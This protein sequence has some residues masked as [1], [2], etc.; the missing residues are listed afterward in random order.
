MVI[1]AFAL[2]SLILTLFHQDF[3]SSMSLQ[4]LVIF[5]PFLGASNK[6][7]S[8]YVKL[9][10]NYGC[11]VITHKPSLID[12]LWP[13]TGLKN[14]TN[15]LTQIQTNHKVG[16]PVVIHSMSIGCYFYGLMLMNINKEP[17]RYKELKFSFRGVVCDSPVVGRLREMATGISMSTFD[18][19]I[20]QKLLESL[21]LSYFAVTRPFTV[22]YYEGA[23]D[24][25]HYKPLPVP[26]VLYM[27]EG[28]PMALPAEFQ[29]LVANWKSSGLDV[30]HKVWANAQ[31]A[32]ILRAYPDKYKTCIYDFLDKVLKGESGFKSRL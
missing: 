11:S 15:F 6:A 3:I 32:G 16:Q 13:R 7:I 8:K 4:P 28:D 25:F 5:L 2:T 30:S 24:A 21:S 26:S 14:S 9:Y 1:I 23:I 29:K 22:Q 17:E 20:M 19:K 12:F 27:A 10:E 18:S 31:H